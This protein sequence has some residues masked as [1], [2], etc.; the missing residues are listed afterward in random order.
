MF[1]KADMKFSFRL[2]VSVCGIKKYNIWRQLGMLFRKRDAWTSVEHFANS[3]ARM[4]LVHS[5]SVSS[6]RLCVSI[7][8]LTCSI[9]LCDL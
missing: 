9:R 4:R 7:I 2:A 5:Y 8:S 1:F 6:L 3:R